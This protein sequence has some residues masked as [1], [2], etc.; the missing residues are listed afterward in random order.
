MKYLFINDLKYELI[1]N[2]KDALN[3]DELINKMTDYFNEFDYV[4]GDY[5]YGKLRLKG[6]CNKDN[7]NYKDI[8]DINN[9]KIYINDFCAY[10]CRYFVIKKISDEIM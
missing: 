2:Y 1:E 6:F 9:L 5:S 3:I 4:I 10:D 8:N 7:K